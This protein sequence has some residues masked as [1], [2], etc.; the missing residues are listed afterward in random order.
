MNIN[1]ELSKNSL[2]DGFCL[3]YGEKYRDLFNTIG[4][5]IIDL[6]I[7]N[8]RKHFYEQALYKI[9]NYSPIWI[10]IK[11]FK[12]DSSFNTIEEL[13]NTVRTELKPFLPT[14]SIEK[15]FE[16]QPYRSFQDSHYAYPRDTNKTG[17]FSKIVDELE[18]VKPKPT[19]KINFKYF[20]QFPIYDTH[21]KTVN[22][23]TEGGFG[24]DQFYYEEVK[25]YLEEGEE[26]YLSEAIPFKYHLIGSVLIREEMR[27]NLIKEIKKHITPNSYYFSKKALNDMIHEYCFPS[28]RDSTLLD[29]QTVCGEEGFSTPKQVTEKLKKFE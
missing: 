6:G 15:L 7:E 10:N 12:P 13:K 9:E 29:I 4:E 19:K 20:K 26:C 17:L 11:F 16:E 1:R 14:N 22:L 21:Q 23:S 2:T 27:L 18:N 8:G 5:Q 25:Y 28:E 3:L 24:L